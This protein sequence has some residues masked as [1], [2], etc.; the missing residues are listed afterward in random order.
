MIEVEIEIVDDSF[1]NKNLKIK[2][3]ICKKEILKVVP[4]KYYY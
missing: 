2:N 1:Q 3:L 4:S